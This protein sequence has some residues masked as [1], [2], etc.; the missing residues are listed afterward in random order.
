MNIFSRIKRDSF[1]K[2]TPKFLVVFIFL[3]IFGMD[4]YAAHLVGG[5]LSYTCVGNNDYR[6]RLRIYRDCAGGGAQFDADVD[7]A[8]Y[9]AAN[10]LIRE[11]TILKGPTVTVSPSATGNPCVTAPP[12][13]CTEYADY[14]STENLPPIAGGYT[15]TWQRCCRNNGIL[16]A[17]NAG[18]E[19]NTYTVTI[20]DNDVACN[21]SP[22]FLDPAPIVLCANTP[23]D[24]ALNVQELDGDSLAFELCDILKSEGTNGCNNGNITPSPACPPPYNT[25]QFVAPFTSSNPIPSS[26]TF[27][28]DPQTGVITGTPNQLGRYVVG[29]CASEYRNGVLMSTVRLDYQFIITGCVPNIVSDMVTPLEDPDILCD[30]F[31][32][33]FTSQSINASQY[34]WDFGIDTITTD[35]S[36]QR[37]PTYTYTHPGVYDVTLIVTSNSGLCSDTVSVSFD[38]RNPVD[39][40]F[41]W[42]GE[43]C[44]ENQNVVFNVD[45]PYPGDATFLWEF[46]AANVPVF[47]GRTPPPIQWVIPGKHK[48]RLLVTSG[49]CTYIAEDSVEIS[50]LTATVD[51][52]PDQTIHKGEVVELTASDGIEWYWWSDTYVEMSSRVTQSTSAILEEPDTL[53][54]YVRVKDEFGC[55]GID[56]LTVI[57]R[58][59]LF[60]SPIN[61]IS[62]DG[63]DRNEL[64]DLSELNPDGDCFITIMNR[65]GKEV[66]NAEAYNNDWN[67]VDFNGNPLPDGTYYYLLRCDKI[68]QFKSAITI[69][70]N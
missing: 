60:V 13:S 54:F 24:L 28:I 33:Q 17:L 35:T 55:D 65:W 62:P 14:V 6:I 2:H 64:L 63:D 23:L 46:G 21:S 30:G 36:T 58:D 9:D 16:N 26:P 59:T 52:G 15:L 51:A 45:G 8:V 22:Q 37:D 29:I 43:T 10:N 42:G 7:I 69:I 40:D 70:R 44:F 4:S 32:I 27:S 20:P 31:T 3:L 11:I 41:S 50:D 25:I 68:V 1:P 57:V 66:W 39:P 49:I 5:D 48:V 56:S 19:G 38:L 47:Q 61:F 12:T 18:S 34:F 67:G 53:I